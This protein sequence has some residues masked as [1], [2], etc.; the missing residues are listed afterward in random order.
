VRV[1]CILFRGVGDNEIKFCN[2]WYESDEPEIF[3]A[4]FRTR[5]DKNG[6][7]ELAERLLHRFRLDHKQFDSSVDAFDDFDSTGTGNEPGQT[8]LFRRAISGAF[9]QPGPEVQD[10]LGDD[11]ASSA[12]L[13][14][15]GVDDGGDDFRTNSRLKE[16][17]GKSSL[18]FGQF[19][20][21]DVV[22]IIL[23]SF[24]APT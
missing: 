1:P 19:P 10:V 4:N 14:S 13:S 16:I 15:V 9:L 7:R 12:R 2:I 17:D 5:F 22:V 21:V 18:F 8:F 11:D 24:D 20:E 3:G 23:P 6:F